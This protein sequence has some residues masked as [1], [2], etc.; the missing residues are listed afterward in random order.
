MAN[1]LA[2]YQIT[3]LNAPEYMLQGDANTVAWED[4][5]IKKIDDY[6]IQITTV[7]LNTAEQVASNFLDR[8]V[9]PVYEPLYEQGM[10]AERTETTY[11][12]TLD[13]WMGAGAYYFDQWEYDNIHVYKKNPD[14]WQADLYHYDQVEVRIVPEMN[15]RVELFEQ[16]LLDSFTPDANTIDA[17]IDDP[18]VATYMDLTVYHIDVNCKNPNNPISGNVN[19]RKALYHAIDREV[20][21]ED[22]FGHMEPTGTYISWAAGQQGGDG[23]RYRETQYGLATTAL[24]ESWGPYGYNPELALEY[25]NKAC[26]EEGV[27]KDEVIKILFTCEDTSPAYAAMGEFFQQEWPKIFEGRVEVEIVTYAGMSATA[28]KKTGDDKWDLSPNDWTSGT[29][30][31]YPHAC[32]MYYLESYGSHPNNY[33]DKEFEAK[34]AELDE[35]KNSG[36]DYEEILKKTQELEEHYLDVVIHIPI[37]QDVAY[38]IFNDKLILPVDE[39]VPS[40]GWG[41][42]FGDSA[43]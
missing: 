25:F 14:F 4:V 37:V 1:F 34:F 15:A 42:E 3:I 10:N 8:S 41:T 36:A 31:T 38:D 6:T 17:Y 23:T 27:A 21:A 16:G 18:R 29:T 20:V 22:L 2:D 11:G 5:G 13:M 35:M 9:Y 32:F 43:E 28:F 26:E 7:G 40:F 12:T 19:Y 33:F 39:Y 30:R 24:V